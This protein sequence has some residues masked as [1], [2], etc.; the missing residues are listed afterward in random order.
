MRRPNGVGLQ[1]RMYVHRFGRSKR[2]R[3]VNSVR[4]FP[5]HRRPQAVARGIGSNREIRSACPLNVFL[6][7]T[8]KRFE[9]E[10]SL[11]PKGSGVG[12]ANPPKKW[13]LRL[14]ISRV[15]FFLQHGNGIDRV[16]RRNVAVNYAVP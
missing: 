1:C 15:V 8:M 7:I 6:D 12:I 4:C 14:W 5:R 16:V 2:L 3:T 11:W 9:A 13:R 10:T